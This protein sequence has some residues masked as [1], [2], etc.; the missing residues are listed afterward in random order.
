MKNETKV[1]SLKSLIRNKFSSQKTW[2]I[3]KMGQWN[4]KLL[5]A[6]HQLITKAS[7]I[8]F[9]LFQLLSMLGVLK[10][11]TSLD[12]KSDGIF[13]EKRKLKIPS[14]IKM[15][16]FQQ[17]SR[18]ALSCYPCQLNFIS[19]KSERRSHKFSTSKNHCHL[20]PTHAMYLILIFHRQAEIATW[21][22]FHKFCLLGCCLLNWYKSSSILSHRWTVKDNQLS[23]SDSEAFPGFNGRQSVFVHNKRNDLL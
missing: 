13:R 11:V 22:M 12:I 4:F 21:Q 16:S 17:N 6:Q 7:K 14:L 5:D 15:F 2:H 19:C 18:G 3:W 23:W 1:K 20:Y 10:K 9:H 8:I